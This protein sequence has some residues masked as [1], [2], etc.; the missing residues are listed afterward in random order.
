MDSKMKARLVEMANEVTASGIMD[1]TMGPVKAILAA[2]DLVFGLWQDAAEPG[3]VGTLLIKGDRAL[4]TIVASNKASAM[5]M[6][7]I[8][9][10][11]FEQAVA[12]KR[13]FG[14]PE[15]HN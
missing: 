12:L 15:A 5:S 4:R 13:T 8:P 11:C 1:G 7:A 6:A 3:G 9:C 2:A 10:T 14:E